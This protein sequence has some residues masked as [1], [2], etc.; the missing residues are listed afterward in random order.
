MLIRLFQL[1]VVGLVTALALP[2][3]PD[4]VSGDPK[5]KSPPEVR[6]GED[7]MLPERV[8]PE[9]KVKDDGDVVDWSVEQVGA[10]AAWAKGYTG[11]GVKV[12]VLD[13]GI[14]S[15]H[16]DLKDGIDSVKDFTGSRS[17]TTDV[18][19]HGT[20]C[21]GSIAARKNGWGTQGVAYESRLLI[22]KV[23]GDSGSGSVEGIA[24]GIEW[25]VANGAKVIS[26]SLGGP[27]SD[28]YIPDALKK[29]EAAGVIVVVAAGNDGNGRPVN[30]PAAY[31]SC[32]AV[33]AIDKNKQLAAFSCTGRKIEATGPGVGVRSTYPGNRFAD[34]S[35]TSMATPNVA[36]V[37][38]LFSQWAD[39]AKVP[40]VERPAKF[41]AW[42]AA[43]AEDLGAKGRDANF[44]YGLPRSGELKAETPVPPTP[45]PPAAGV[46]L[47][48]KDLTPEAQE[49]LRKAGFTEFTFRLGKAT[50]VAP[51]I[52]V[53]ELVK[54][55]SAG[56]TLV[57]AVGVPL[58]TVKYPKGYELEA[59]AEALGIDPGV[60][61]ASP[62]T[63]VS[64]KPLE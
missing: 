15:D 35:G 3:A 64:L 2:K 20:H 19:G 24:Q 37:A 30:Y 48:W 49:R 22:G 46:D 9:H 59:D 62:V 29:A 56:E 25:A 21:A 60:Y 27:G 38:A 13:T 6:L 28:P 34:L 10:P 23:L 58:D 5:G 1:S 55:V 7:E 47:G 11:K 33:S 36:G 44:G 53:E 12:A 16:K 32:V 51:K 4:N 39:E 63:K 42:L 52:G 31:E 57:V 26:M 50:A 41:R 14:D 8:I 43:T 54:R 17:G 61:E 40:Q 18:V 45:T